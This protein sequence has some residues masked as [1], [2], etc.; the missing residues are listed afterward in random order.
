M[1][2]K[3]DSTTH[4]CRVARTTATINLLVTILR[5]VAKCTSRPLTPIIRE[6]EKKYP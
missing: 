5:Q 2:N 6:I 4:W 1:T 3:A